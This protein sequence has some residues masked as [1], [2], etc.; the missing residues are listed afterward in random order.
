VEPAGVYTRQNSKSRGR[1]HILESRRTPTGDTELKR[2]A[3]ALRR[4]AD[5][6]ETLA[7][8]RRT[9]RRAVR[10]ILAP[11][12]RDILARAAARLPAPEAKTLLDLPH[13]LKNAT[14]RVRLSAEILAYH[15]GTMSTLLHKAA[16]P[17]PSSRK[18]SV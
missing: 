5:Q 8:E 9:T 7:E 15:L 3:E 13:R 6:L 11:C 2:Q 14:R 10:E 18:A 4:L 17:I 16:L 12:D 1:N